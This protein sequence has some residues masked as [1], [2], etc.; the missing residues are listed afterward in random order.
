MTRGAKMRR[1]PLSTRSRRPKLPIPGVLL[2]AN[3]WRRPPFFFS[4]SLMISKYRQLCAVPLSPLHH[5]LN[6]PGRKGII[7]VDKIIPAHTATF[8]ND[9]TE[10]LNVVHGLK[11][12]EAIDKFIDTKI[13]ETYIIIDPIF[14]D[15]DFSREGWK[16]KVRK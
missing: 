6:R 9:Y 13:A 11:Q 1:R 14:A 12:T 5:L 2:S 10:L 4:R 15:C 8:E 16:E 3:N 7:R